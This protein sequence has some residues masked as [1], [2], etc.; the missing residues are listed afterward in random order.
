MAKEETKANNNE[1]IR[2]EESSQKKLTLKRGTYKNKKTG[3]DLFDYF[4]EGELRGKKVRAD[5][6]P[7]DI[8]G[9]RLLEVVF[10]DVDSVDLIISNN[11]MVK[12]DTGEVVEFKTYMATSSDADGTYEC[13][14]LPKNPSDKQT[15]EMLLR[16]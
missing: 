8:N 5:F 13:K 6:Q 7:T 16:K 3:E 1:S 12:E 10:G 4:V 2:A 11:R 9:Y 15:L 14:V